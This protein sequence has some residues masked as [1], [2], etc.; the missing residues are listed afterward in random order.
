MSFESINCGIC[1]GI[2]VIFLVVR[3]Y[4][5]QVV[6]WEFWTINTIAVSG[7]TEGASG[8]TRAESGGCALSQLRQL[9]VCG[10]GWNFEKQ[11]SP[12]RA[13]VGKHVYTYYIYIYTC[14]Q[15]RQT[16]NVIYIYVI[17]YAIIC[18]MYITYIIICLYSERI[19]GWSS[20]L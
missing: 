16:A 19:P 18:N 11:S 10:V 6:V 5:S 9:E 8:A 7:G 17:I 4:T 3:I 20:N 1:V 2:W 12:R 13:R 14:T 15:I